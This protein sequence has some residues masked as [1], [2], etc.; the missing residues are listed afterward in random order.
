[1]N[2]AHLG[3]EMVVKR[4]LKQREKNENERISANKH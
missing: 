2:D 4:A 3:A 1:M